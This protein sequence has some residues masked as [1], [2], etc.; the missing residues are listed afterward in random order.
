MASF[1]VYKQ[2]RIVSLWQDGCKVPTIAKTLAKENLPATR[3]GV[4]KFLS[5]KR[6]VLLVDEKVQAKRQK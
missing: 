2:H 3:Q 1:S 5:M 6:V 4:Q